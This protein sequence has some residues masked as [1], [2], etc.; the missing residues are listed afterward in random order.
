MRT[1][2]NQINYKVKHILCFVPFTVY[3]LVFLAV[4]IP[5]YFKLKTISELPESAYKA[6]FSVLLT[7]ALLFS[8]SILCFAFIT[9][10]ISFIYLKI[11]QRSQR[12]QFTLKSDIENSQLYSK[13]GI[14]ISL[15]PVLMPLLGFIKLRVGYGAPQYSKKITPSSSKSNWLSFRFE[16]LFYWHLPEIRE[17]QIDSVILYIEDFFHF[18]SFALILKTSNRFHILPQKQ[19]LKTFNSQPRKTEETDVRIEELKRVEGELINYKNFESSDDVRRIVWKIYAKNK[20]LVVR[21]P[22]I[23]DPY[24]SHMYFYPSFHT[25]TD[26][27]THPVISKT[28]L[29]HYKTVCWSVYQQLLQKGFEVSYIPDQLLPPAESVD[30]TKQVQFHITNSH[31]QRDTGLNEFVKPKYA[32][33]VLISGLNEVEEVQKLIEQFGN[34]I[35]FLF[36]PLTDKLHGS[37]VS[38]WLYKAFVQSEDADNKKGLTRWNISPLRQRLIENEKQIKKLLKQTFK[39]E[40]IEQ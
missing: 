31:W 5:G 30:K 7:L 9:T 35:V 14:S 29:N 16:G 32:S 25:F 28:F 11:Q 39:A 40:V 19:D 17:Y 23:M 37:I 38:H 27:N 18:F 21:I 33:V 34:E 15:Q 2:I 20:E 13:Q 3:F 10:L 36:V 1:W 22:E 12:L 4:V 6:V 26:V 24:A 8:L